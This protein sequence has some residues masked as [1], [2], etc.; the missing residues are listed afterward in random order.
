M[1]RRWLRWTWV[2]FALLLIDIALTSHAASAQAAGSPTGTSIIDTVSIAFLATN[3]RL[4]AIAATWSSTI[5][6][7]LVS[8]ELLWSLYDC[9]RSSSWSDLLD[10]FGFRLVIFCIGVFLITNQVQLA[11]ELNAEITTIASSFATGSTTGAQLTPGGIA[12]LGWTDA[13]AV[14][15]AEP[16]DPVSAALLALPSFLATGLLMISFVLV[17]LDQLIMNLGA[18]FCVAVGSML[19]GFVATRWTRP[20]AAIWP[21]MMMGTLLLN[22]VVDA[23][24]GVGNGLSTTILATTT[25]MNGLGVMAVL[26]NIA[27][28][29]AIG[30]VYAFF[31]C[32]ITGLIGF[33]GVSTAMHA[34]TTVRNTMMAAASYAG[35]RFGS[36]HGGGGAS[37]PRA[38]ASLEA[39]KQAKAKG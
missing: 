4:T 37:A 5:F 30:V 35:A 7:A 24:A 3:A 27:V 29:F 32:S 6:Y 17:A 9:L 25:A 38:V 1:K 12:S 39:A 20:Y 2:A 19:L 13:T 15:N 22:V 8:F 26:P 18:Q 36:S 21:R 10:G 23:A 28:I 33:L 16:S 31:V 14:W 11:N 34:S